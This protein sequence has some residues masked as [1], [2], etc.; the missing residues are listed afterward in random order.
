[1]GERDLI[2]RATPKEPLFFRHP[3]P[4]AIKVP[5]RGARI[6]ANLR[7]FPPLRDISKISQFGKISEG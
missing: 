7:F 2:Y 6:P 4:L 3:L 5:T 1:M